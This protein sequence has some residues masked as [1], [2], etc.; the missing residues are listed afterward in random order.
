M[1]LAYPV[2]RVQVGTNWRLTR[3]EPRMSP[4]SSALAPP[5]LPPSR[6]I[7]G[8][9]PDHEEQIPSMEPTLAAVVD[10]RLHFL[11]RSLSL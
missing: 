4:M 11:H 7:G 8:T 2:E 1:P 10:L 6:G 5:S 3:A 9:R